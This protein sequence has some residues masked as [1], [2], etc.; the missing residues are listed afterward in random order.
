MEY[1]VN[2]AES[3]VSIK[4]LRALKIIIPLPN[5]KSLIHK[6]QASLLNITFYIFGIFLSFFFPLLVSEDEIF[7]WE[8]WTT[9]EI[10]LHIFPLVLWL[11]SSL[12]VRVSWV[13]KLKNAE[14]KPKILW[15]YIILKIVKIGSS[16]MSS[17]TYPET[18]LAKRKNEITFI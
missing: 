6:H 10:Y 3:L 16:E 14:W 7:I 11:Y 8:Q 4:H 12:V 1:A 5:D 15:Y 9:L 18:F 2:R 13:I 17:Y